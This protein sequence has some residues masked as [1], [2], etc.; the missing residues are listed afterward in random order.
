MLDVGTCDV[1]RLAH[2]DTVVERV[3][4]SEAPQFSE[5]AV[6]V[7]TPTKHGLIG[8]EGIETG[9]VE[10]LEVPHGVHEMP[11]NEPGFVSFLRFRTR[12]RVPAHHR[13]TWFPGRNVHACDVAH[14]AALQGS[15]HRWQRSA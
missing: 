2:P 4:G 13:C 1:R 14:T 11:P 12:R 9:V 7:R 8:D 6:W 10:V 3:Y 15:A 5:L